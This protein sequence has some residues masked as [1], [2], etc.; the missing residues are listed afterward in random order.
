MTKFIYQIGIVLLFIYFKC[1]ALFGNDK[2]QKAN[3]GRK[4]WKEHLNLLDNKKTYWIH[5]ASHGE[6][7]MALPL[8]KRF[9]ENK[10]NQVVISFF[11]PSG[12][13]NFKF[14]DPNLH[15]IYLPLDTKK[16][17]NQLIEK[18]NPNHVIFVKYDLWMNTINACHENKVPI[19]IFNAKFRQDQWYFKTYGNWAKKNLQKVNQIFTIDQSTFK[20]LEKND[21]KNVKVSGDTRYDQV[22]VSQENKVL[23]IIKPCLII[24]SSWAIEEKLIAKVSSILPDLQYIIAPHEVEEKRLLEVKKYFGPKSKLLSEI[25]TN[26]EIPE[27]LIIDRIGLLAELYSSTDIAFIG[28]GFTG[29]L[30][31]IIEP[32]AKGNIVLFGPEIHK[33]PEAEEMIKKGIAHIIQDEASIKE[34]LDEILNDKNK[35][36]TSKQRAIEFVNNKKGATDLIYNS[37]ISEN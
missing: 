21:F 30:H 13:Q 22:S 6:G 8:I 2:A 31:N 7:L 15:K 10:G 29:K 23:N 34:K 33:Y 14:E 11:S 12:H 28:G 1:A 4:E 25:D 36:K 17:A 26:K 18:I 16:N 27:V 24:G 9:L 32:S 35:L 19:T 3:K 5:A 20:L 37:I